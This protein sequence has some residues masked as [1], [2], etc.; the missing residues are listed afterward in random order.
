[1]AVSGSTAAVWSLK[2]SQ[3]IPSQLA[4]TEGDKMQTN[5]YIATNLI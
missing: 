3:V 1:M 4:N 2:S 5:D